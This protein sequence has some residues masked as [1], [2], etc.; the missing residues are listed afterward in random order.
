MA[1]FNAATQKLGVANPVTAFTESEFGRSLQPSGPAALRPCGTGNDQGWGCLVQWI[2]GL[3]VEA[4]SRILIWCGIWLEVRGTLLSCV[5]RQ[6][7][8]ALCHSQPSFGIRRR[9]FAPAGA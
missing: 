4:G 2:W 8:G 6:F 7:E 5:S 3:W 1:A 9:V